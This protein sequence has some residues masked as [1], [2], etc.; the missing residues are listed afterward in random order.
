M[1]VCIGD[2]SSSPCSAARRPLAARGAGAAIGKASGI[3]FLALIAARGHDFGE[4]AVGVAAA[5]TRL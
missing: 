1:T 5:R 2:A 4:T 3:A